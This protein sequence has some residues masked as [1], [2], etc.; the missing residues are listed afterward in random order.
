[1]MSKLSNF[2]NRNS[3][4]NMKSFRL[5]LNKLK[6]MTFWIKMKSVIMKW[7][8]LV[9]VKK[10]V[11]LMRWISMLVW[12]SIRRTEESFG[13]LRRK[14]LKKKLRSKNLNTMYR[15]SLKKKNF[16]KKRMSLWGLT[17]ETW[18]MHL[19]KWMMKKTWLKLK[20]FLTI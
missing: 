7:L 14:P 4:K 12:L 19:K 13:W 11:I 20:T 18:A 16:W 5:R 17:S 3:S 6:K 8:M 1:M 9:K 10:R 2:W 15:T